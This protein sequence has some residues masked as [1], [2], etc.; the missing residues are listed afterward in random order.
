[1]PD[2]FGELISLEKEKSIF[3][4]ELAT[5]ILIITCLLQVLSY[6]SSFNQ[7]LRLPRIQYDDQNYFFRYRQDFL[8]IKDTLIRNQVKQVG[9]LYRSDLDFEHYFS[10]YTLAPEVLVE[11]G[12]TPE[13]NIGVFTQEEDL[14]QAISDK[15]FEV[16]RQCGSR[17]FLL[18]KK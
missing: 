14:A 9:F 6:V 15:N 3:I 5:I 2:N 16:A 11:L 18:R 7:L 4:K 13:Y 1:L 8:C 12:T 17:I 10:A